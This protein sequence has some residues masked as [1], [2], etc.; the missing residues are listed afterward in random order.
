AA[1]GGVCVPCVCTQT[2]RAVSGAATTK[3]GAVRTKS[4]CRKGRIHSTTSKRSSGKTATDTLLSIA[5][6]K[7]VRLSQ[8]LQS[9][10]QPR[11]G[12]GRNSLSTKSSIADRKNDIARRFLRCVIQA[13]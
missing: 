11:A 1:R 7:A 8:Y 9:C 12:R 2:L 6:T 4:L 10:V 3:N 13:T 5:K